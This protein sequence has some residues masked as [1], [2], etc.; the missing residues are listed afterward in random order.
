MKLNLKSKTLKDVVLTAVYLIFSIL[1]FVSAVKMFNFVES[2]ICIVL[3]GSGVVC[4]VIYAL[5]SSEDKNFKLLIYGILA[6]VFAVGMIM[7][8][9]F[10]GISLSIIIGYNGIA[11]VVSSVKTKKQNDK[12]WITEFVIGIIVII[13]SVVT[14]ILSGTNVAKR[15]ISIFFAVILLINGVYDLVALIL[16]LKNL[17][18]RELINVQEELKNEKIVENSEENKISTEET[19]KE[20]DIIENE[21]K[22]KEEINQESK[23]DVENLKQEKK[24]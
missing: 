15:I 10:F 11:L 13:L 20:S 19:L 6:V 24:S 12:S 14:L 5:M 3:L 16:R 1:F 9:L 4:I 17:K 2:L 22:Q 21:E 23:K 7:V 8:P 18:N